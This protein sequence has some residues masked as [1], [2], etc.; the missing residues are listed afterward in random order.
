MGNAESEPERLCHAEGAAP[1]GYRVFNVRPGSPATS[2]YEIVEKEDGTRQ[3]IH[4][5]LISYLDF[6]VGIN[7]L[8]LVR[9]KMSCLSRSLAF[10]PLSTHGNFITGW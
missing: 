7:G 1:F 5:E 2:G 10:S 3:S 9:Q 8:V 6:I 4:G